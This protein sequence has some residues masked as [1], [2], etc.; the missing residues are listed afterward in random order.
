MSRTTDDPL[1][2]YMRF[3]VTETEGARLMRQA[4]A[5]SMTFSEFARQQLLR[6]K[7]QTRRGQSTP[8]E[9]PVPPLMA[10][11]EVRSLAFQMQ[12]VGVNLNQIVKA[13]HSF[14]RPPPPELTQLLGEIRAYVRQ[15]QKLPTRYEP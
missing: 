8:E 7:R 6:S 1:D 3:R 14:R 13:M 11:S 12:K 4:E 9:G 2:R 15:A 5:Q 10:D